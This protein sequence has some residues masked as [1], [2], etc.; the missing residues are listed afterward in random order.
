MVWLFVFLRVEVH[1]FYGYRW[2]LVFWSDLNYPFAHSRVISRLFTGCLKLLT[3]EKF[4]AL[5]K[6]YKVSV[7][8]CDYSCCSEILL[9]FVLFSMLF[10]GCFPL[11]LLTDMFSDV[12]YVLPY[13][14]VISQL[15]SG[16]P[17]G[18]SMEDF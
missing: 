14:W 7:H 1:L 15:Y 13:H 3:I 11:F 17:K 8:V 4:S 5:M 18:M 12:K 10:Q 16:W 2:L 6:I 9:N